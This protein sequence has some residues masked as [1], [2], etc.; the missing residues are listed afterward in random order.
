MTD[1]TTADG[2]IPVFVDGLIY[3]LQAVGGISRY[4]DELVSGL[5]SRHEVEPTLLLPDSPLGGVPD[6][7]ATRNRSPIP[8]LQRWGRLSDRVGK[9]I[10]RQQDKWLAKSVD[11][12]PGAVFFS[13]YYATL[14]LKNTPTVVTVYDLIYEKFPELFSADSDERFRVQRRDCMRQAERVIAISETT[15]QDIV[16]LCG[17]APNKIDVIHLG[18]DAPA[19]RRDASGDRRDWSD[20]FRVHRP[21]VCFVGSRGGYKNF[22]LVIQA[23]AAWNDSVDLVVAGAPWTDAEQEGLRQAGIADRTHLMVHPSGRDLAMMYGGCLAFIYPSLYEGFGLPPLEAMACGAPVV[24]AMAGSIP[25]VVGEAAEHFDPHDAKDLV[26][27]LNRAC[28]PTRSA[29]LRQC[30][31]SRLAN[32]RWESTVD[33]TVKTFQHALRRE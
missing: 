31:Q 30:G 23:F 5:A 17:I 2:P 20:R 29:E 6:S 24:A 8:W 11:A 9:Q 26:R 33:Q 22:D 14:P 28:E 4:L 13:P 1:P 19:W 32:F 12:V 15:R 18:V 27:A 16:E 10:N 21:Y 7:V 25:E 3:Q